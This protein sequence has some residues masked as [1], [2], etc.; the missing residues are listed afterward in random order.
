[1]ISE[2]KILYFKR[3][4]SLVLGVFI[5]VFISFR[6]F[7]S[8]IVTINGD[9]IPAEEL[10]IYM[11]QE[12]ASAISEMQQKEGS[13]KKDEYNLVFQKALQQLVINKVQWQKA[14]GL[15]LVENTTIGQGKVIT[16][17]RYSFFQDYYREYKKRPKIYPGITNLGKEQLYMELM[18][19]IGLTLKLKMIGEMK[20]LDLDKKLDYYNRVFIPGL[21][22]NAKI[23]VNKP[24]AWYF[25]T[26][27][28]GNL[29]N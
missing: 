3:L 17:S 5:L 11:V 23:Q 20:G 2:R 19:R 15:S 12:R 6:L 22:S 27:V 14:V 13:E 21:A 4:A 25:K 26:F 28:Y 7:F 9:E 8:F 16:H 18:H 24:G 10:L 1:M 29:A